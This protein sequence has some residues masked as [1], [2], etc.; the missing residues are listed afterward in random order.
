MRFLEIFSGIS[1]SDSKA[2]VALAELKGL[3][4]TLPN[5]NIL[6][7]DIVLKEAKASSEIENVITINDSLYQALTDKSFKPDSATK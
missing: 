1:V 5:L 2:A 4:H 3:A 7:N 6:I